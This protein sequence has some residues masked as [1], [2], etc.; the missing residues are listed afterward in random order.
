M[1]ISLDKLRLS[2]HNIGLFL[3]VRLKGRRSDGHLLS[4]LWGRRTQRRTSTHDC[5]GVR[6]LPSALFTIYGWVGPT[7][8]LT[9]PTATS[10][11]SAYINQ[12]RVLSRSRCERRQRVAAVSATTKLYSALEHQQIRLTRKTY[13]NASDIYSWARWDVTGTA[14]KK[15][16]SDSF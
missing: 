8:D 16:S 1:K 13:T 2:N 11:A 7:I 6:V 9:T 5:T 3:C 4:R 15:N 12:P 14:K 10:S